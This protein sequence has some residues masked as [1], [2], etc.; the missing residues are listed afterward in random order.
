MTTSVFSSAEKKEVIKGD[1]LY[2]PKMLY[3]K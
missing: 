2:G 1:M 3:V